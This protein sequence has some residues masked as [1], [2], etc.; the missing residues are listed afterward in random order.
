MLKKAIVLMAYNRPDYFIQTCLSVKPQV[1]DEDVII[2]LDGA[3]N[4][5]KG[6]SSAKNAKLVERSRAIALEVFPKARIYQ[7]SVNAGCGLQWAAM[8]STVF[9]FLHYD[10]IIAI[11]DDLVLS[12]YYIRTVN[13]MLYKFKDDFRVG[14]VSAFSE[15]NKE[16]HDPYL[17]CLTTCGH[18]WGVGIWKSRWAMWRDNMAEWSKVFHK[19]KESDIE[20]VLEHVRSLGGKK[21]EGSVNDSLLYNVMLKNKQIPISTVANCAKYIG[22]IGAHGTK[23]FFSSRG[24]DDM[25]F[26]QSSVSY[27]PPDNDFFKNALNHLKEAYG[28]YI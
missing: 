11:E 8:L 12:N 17:D 1:T 13:K 5:E 16:E 18:L 26:H 23:E 20:K 10:E 2:F 28:F 3:V 14:M 19:H 6:E 27:T 15:R 7:N 9:D 4:T 22:E 21:T 24:F 25:P